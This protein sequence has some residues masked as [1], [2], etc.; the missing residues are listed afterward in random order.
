V[1]SGLISQIAR[2]ELLDLVLH[3]LPMCIWRC[4]HFA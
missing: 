1:I 2:I 3:Q 4:I